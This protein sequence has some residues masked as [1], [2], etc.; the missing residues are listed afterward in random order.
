VNGVYGQKFN[1]QG[2]FQW[3]ATGLVIVPLGSDT[4]SFVENVSLGTGSL[5]VWNDSPAYGMDTLQA[6]RLDGQGN[7][8]CGPVAVSSA[9]ATKYGLSIDITQAH[10]T[11]VAW[12]DNRIG[13]NSIYIQN[14]QPDCALGR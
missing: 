8:T 6:I 3:G 12:A 9:P 4:Q 1:G 2:L 10:M 5:V 7:V 11:A 14:I 13:N